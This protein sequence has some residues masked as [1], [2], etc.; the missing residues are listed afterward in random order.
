MAVQAL[1]VDRGL[2]FEIILSL[3]ICKSPFL[4]SISMSFPKTRRP[5]LSW[6]GTS[7]IDTMVFTLEMKSSMAIL[8]RGVPLS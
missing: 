5:K 1:G 2:L 7:R 4:S 8:L 3:S 6:G